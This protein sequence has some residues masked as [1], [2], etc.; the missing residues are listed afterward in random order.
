MICKFVHSK[1]HIILAGL[2]F[3]QII[4]LCPFTCKALDIY[5]IMTSELV[6]IH[7]ENYRFKPW[8][9]IQWYHYETGIRTT[10]GSISSDRF[11]YDLDTKTGVDLHPNFNFAYRYRQKES[12]TQ[13]LRI[14]RSDVMFVHHGICAGFTGMAD[15]RKEFNDFGIVFGY[16][17][18][19]HERLFCRVVLPDVAFNQKTSGSDEY[20]KTPLQ[21]NLE[22]NWS[23]H[24]LE[25]AG[26]YVLNLPWEFNSDSSTHRYESSEAELLIAY[27]RPIDSFLLEMDYQSEDDQFTRASTENHIKTHFL[28]RVSLNYNRNL[29]PIYSM[30]ARGTWISISG[31]DVEE[32]LT[33][34]SETGSLNPFSYRRNDAILTFELARPV[35]KYNRISAQIIT[36]VISVDSG[37]SQTY[38][39]KSGE[40][41]GKLAAEYIRQFPDLGEL[42]FGLTYKLD[43]N[44]FGGGNLRL[45]IHL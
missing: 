40:F 28:Y 20:T 39:D 41:S 10:A 45:Q 18:S 27:K 22:G 38:T 42:V 21:F 36:G 26:E 37:N 25:I 29:S 30:S 34:N 14:H 9:M 7:E 19:S 35:G 23:I 5:R 11:Y 31:D 33:G 6:F 13:Y 15:S 43:E 17:K 8:E 1:N 16:Q 4:G 12:Y 3:C 32:T 2:L 44:K 24:S